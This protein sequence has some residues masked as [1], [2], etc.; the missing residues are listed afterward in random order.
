MTDRIRTITVVL[1]RDVRIDDDAQTIIDA[2]R[3][4]KGVQDVLPG[5]VVDFHAHHARD[6]AKIELRTELLK[7]LMP[8]WS[9][10]SK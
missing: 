2:I 6:L 8:E 9:K 5:E 4:I 1:E 3:M 7:M 10:E